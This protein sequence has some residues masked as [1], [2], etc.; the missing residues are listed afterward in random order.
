M[1]KNLIKVSVSKLFVESIF[2]KCDKIACCDVCC[3]KRT[4]LCK[5]C[6][7]RESKVKEL[8]DSKVEVKFGR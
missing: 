1:K 7:W 8:A 3:H 5:S 6:E 4:F 2:Q